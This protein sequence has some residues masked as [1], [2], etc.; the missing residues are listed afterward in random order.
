[1]KDKIEENALAIRRVLYMADEVVDA[2]YQGKSLTVP[3][4]LLLNQFKAIAP[5]FTSTVFKCV[6]NK[7]KDNQFNDTPATH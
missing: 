6:Q 3:M 1:M 7:E 2:Y 4:S 5:T